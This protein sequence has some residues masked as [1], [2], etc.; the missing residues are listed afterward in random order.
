M[1]C[2]GLYGVL[3]ML[4]GCLLMYFPSEAERP[5]YALNHAA[6]GQLRARGAA[7]RVTVEFGR[8]YREIT[9][10]YRSWQLDKWLHF[11]ETYSLLLLTPE[12]MDP[13]MWTCLRYFALQ[14]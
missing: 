9:R 5:W 12:H 6:R 4:L 7:I 3:R 14:L 11:L 8:P 2:T 13:R 10:S 1:C